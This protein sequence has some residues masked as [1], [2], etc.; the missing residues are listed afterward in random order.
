MGPEFPGLRGCRA[1][2]ISVKYLVRSV[3]AACALL[4]LPAL[5]AAADGFATSNVNMRSGPST[6]YPAV[7]VI[8][9]GAPVTIYGCLEETPW[10]DVSY[11]RVRGWVAG[12][13]VQAVYRQNRVYVEPEYYRPLGIPTIT[14]DI[15][16]Y[17]DRNYRRRDF[18]RERDRWRDERPSITRPW[19]NDNRR[20]DRRRDNDWDNNNRWDRRR[21]NEVLDN[22]RN[23]RDRNRDRDRERNR[24]RDRNRNADNGGVR[25]EDGQQ[26]NTSR[27]PD[28][29]RNYD[30]G[31]LGDPMGGREARPRVRIEGNC[32]PGQDGCN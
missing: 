30:D 18:Y 28:R 6:R 14:F 29:V 22:E 4:A 1:G 25:I 8:P 24:D 17:W 9:A 20:W 2:E 12:R 10:C 3:L 23:D 15:D 7:T 21:N 19:E 31:N 32:L 26:N 27:N 16:T 13:Y 5:A 11:G